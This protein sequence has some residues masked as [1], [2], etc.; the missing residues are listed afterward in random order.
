MIRIAAPASIASILAPSNACLTDSVGSLPGIA[1]FPFGRTL[2][3]ELQNLIDAGFTNAQRKLSTRLLKERRD[4]TD[5]MS[6]VR[7]RVEC[8]RIFCSSTASLLRISRTRLTLMYRGLVA[9]GLVSVLRGISRVIQPRLVSE[10]TSLFSKSL[11][12]WS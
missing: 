8:G 2:H 10:R 7:L 9:S 6:G 4:C 1:N 11:D 5:S 3:C 12:L